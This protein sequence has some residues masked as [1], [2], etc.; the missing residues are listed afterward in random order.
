ML[1]RRPTAVR[2]RRP[3]A[4][5][6]KLCKFAD[7]YIRSVQDNGRSDGSAHQ[8]RPREFASKLALATDQAWRTVLFAR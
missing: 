5:A 4:T 7:T 3:Q 2:T 1:L 6:A 8:P